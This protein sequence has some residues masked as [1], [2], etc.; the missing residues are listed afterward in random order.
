MGMGR[1]TPERPVSYCERALLVIKE[2]KYMSEKTN[3]K[4]VTCPNC[5]FGKWEGDECANCAKITESIKKSKSEHRQ[6]I[7][8]FSDTALK[9]RGF[10][11]KISPK[12]ARQLK[13][14]LETKIMK[15]TDFEKVILY[16]L[17]DRSYKNLGPSIATI[18]S[19]TVLNSLINKMKNRVQF[20]KELEGYAT[21]YFNSGLRVVVSGQMVDIAA[22][23]EALKNKL[24]I[25]N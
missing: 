7:E 2:Q 16:F 10:R 5:L 1:N 8:F 17:A 4:P 19:S 18:M 24:S 13:N 14:I 22:Q 15:Q 12:D 23:L 11:P 20:Y 9:A 21:Q 3:K 6:L 25:K